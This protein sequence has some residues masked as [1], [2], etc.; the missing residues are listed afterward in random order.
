MKVTVAVATRAHADALAPNMRA[1]DRAEV[2]SS[3]LA[4]PEEA[5]A[6]SLDLSTMAWAGC[7]DGE[8]VCMFGAGPA[9][10]LGTTGIPWLLASDA[11]ENHATAFLR[12]NRA[13]VARMRI[14][15]DRLENWVD[16]R[17]AASIAWLNWLGFTIHP[18]APFGSLGLPFH[19]FTME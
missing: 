4:T 2:W 19:R 6:R 10:L 9:T 5:L 7:V 18:A 11:L 3:M 13:Y 16:A 15:F 8:V 14:A 12:R 1:A 17:N